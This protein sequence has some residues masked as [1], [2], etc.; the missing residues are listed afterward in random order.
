MM[1]K[2]VQKFKDAINAKVSAI[3][4]IREGNCWVCG[5]TCKNWGV[6]VPAD[7]ADAL[8][9]GSKDEDTARVA[10]FPVCEIHD[11]NNAENIEKVV[12]ALRIKKITMSN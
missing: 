12:Q 1:E 11:M 8:G 9:F 4:G 10:F 3:N 2:D 7:N 5:E 6:C